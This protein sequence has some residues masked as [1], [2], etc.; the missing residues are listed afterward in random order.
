MLILR[1]FAS[2]ALVA[3]PSL[4]LA[5]TGGT[6]EIPLPPAPPESP[7]ESPDANPG[8]DPSQAPPPPPASGS[9]SEV[10]AAPP[11]AAPTPTGL[12]QSE[13]P[14]APAP[15]ASASVALSTGSD[16]PRLSPTAAHPSPSGE[17][18]ILRVASAAGS[19][20]GLVRVGLGFEFFTL[21]DFFSEGD[22]NTRFAGILSLSGS[23][24][25]FL[26]LW[27]NVRAVSNNNTLT[28]PNLLQSQGDLQFGIKGFYPVADLASV[29]IDAQVTLLSGIGEAGYDFGASEARFRALFTADLTKAP[30]GGVPI[31]AHLN[32]GFILDNSA[33]LLS[34]E[35]ELTIPERFALG[36]SEFNRVVVGAGLEVPVPYV[37][38]Y[39]E[40][41]I[42]FPVDYLATP[43]V[44]ISGRA[45]RE[46]QT[47]D[48][49]A[50]NQ[51]ARPAVQRIIP[52]RITPGVRIRPLDG[53][54]I[55]VAVEIG[56]TP[57]QAVGVPAVPDYN[58]I[59]LLSYAMDPFGVR[60]PKRGGPSGPPVAVPVIIPEAREGPPGARVAGTVVDKATGQPL[61]DA[62]VSF[63]GQLPVATSADGRFE[64]N[65]LPPGPIRM[66]VRKD[67]F[68]AGEAELQVVEGEPAEVAVALEPKIVIGQVGGLIVDGSGAAVANASIR[69]VP[70]G[71]GVAQTL[72][73][74][75][76]GHFS[77]SLDEGTWRLTVNTPGFLRT[78]R[79]VEITAAETSPEIALQLTPRGEVG[80]QVDGRRIRLPEPLLYAKGETTP[81]AAARGGLDL[82]ADLILADGTLNIEVGGHTDSRGNELDN[83][84][85]S[86]ARA[87]AARQYLLDRGVAPKQV[88]AEG[89]GSTRPVAPNLTR[90]GR[91]RNRRIDFVVR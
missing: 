2:L 38:P 34:D 54:A 90:A 87:Q 52:Q 48:P 70:S 16:E 56:L 40:Y 12:G 49:T 78:G 13:V 72:T 32:G 69:A 62:I 68:T 41:T 59:T 11:E 80:A 29:G 3:T 21:N 33:E 42:E 76:D 74:G 63:G 1:F 79:L 81:N 10:A 5:Q 71:A 53:L 55:D 39:L 85:V 50:Q 57:D 7:A 58:V 17:T 83:R 22:E 67:G 35:D 46:A 18:G 64:S 28:S 75:P 43:G 91:E 26:E 27:L 30:G 51:V 77:A 25:D 24:I 8:P 47:A 19:T 60:E 65:D 82:V 31:R 89:Y 88:A 86:V 45:L 9:A 36:V 66:T 73:A 61:G 84:E 6:P 4:A 44:V 23:P 14:P 37:T 15:E 20:P